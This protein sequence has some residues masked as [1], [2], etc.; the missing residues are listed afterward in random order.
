MPVLGI[1]YGQQT[2][3]AQL[4]GEVEPSDH[5]EFGR[6]FV[7]IS[8]NCALFDGVWQPGERD[9]VWMS[10]GDRVTRLPPGFRVVGTSEGAPFAS[11][12]DDARQIST[13]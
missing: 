5:R 13:A 7:E 9:Q 10:H 2:M 11:I 6:A 8:D 1:C 4:G 3:C 12:A